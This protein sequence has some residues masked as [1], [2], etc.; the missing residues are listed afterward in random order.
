[1]LLK[2]HTASQIVCFYAMVTA[3]CILGPA[4]SARRHNSQK[5]EQHLLKATGIAQHH[6]SLKAAKDDNTAYGQS[7]IRRHN[8]GSF[9]SGSFAKN[10]LAGTVA[11]YSFVVAAPHIFIVSPTCL[12]K[13]YSRL[14]LPGYYS[15]LFRYTPF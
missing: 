7:A 9:T 6:T 13:T 14:L 12:I 15:F 2:K 3:V 10:T 8:E 11:V 4:L 5:G 1:M